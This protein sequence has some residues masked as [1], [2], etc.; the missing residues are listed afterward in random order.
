MSGDTEQTW[1]RRRFVRLRAD[2]DVLTTQE[3]GQ[4]PRHTAELAF[5]SARSAAGS[6]IIDPIQEKYIDIEMQK[7]KLQKQEK[8]SFGKNEPSKPTRLTCDD[9]LGL[10][11]FHVAV[12]LTG[13]RSQISF[14]PVVQPGIE[15]V[16][17]IRVP[18]QRS[19]W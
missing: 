1:S 11:R 18:G 5:I 14:W 10:V 8:K 6:W 4:F 13:N 2:S 3:P 15:R 16:R 7:H 17:V 12:V 19:R 9:P